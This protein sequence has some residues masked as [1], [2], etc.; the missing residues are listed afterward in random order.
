MA[1]ALPLLLMHA[2]LHHLSDHISPLSSL[3][4]GA[5]LAHIHVVSSPDPLSSHL[6]F[7]GLIIYF[8]HLSVE[9][10]PN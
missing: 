4:V 2:I 9:L 6:S 8:A 1:P 10:K 3:W 7:G 5:E